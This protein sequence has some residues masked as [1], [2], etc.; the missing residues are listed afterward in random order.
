MHE[1]NFGAVVEEMIVQGGDAQTIIQG[2]AHD[3]VNFIL[4]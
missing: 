2:G 3:W 1:K 4:K